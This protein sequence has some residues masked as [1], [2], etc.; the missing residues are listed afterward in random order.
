LLVKVGTYYGVIPFPYFTSL[1][2][3]V[4]CFEF[5]VCDGAK[6]VLFFLN[7]GRFLSLFF[8]PFSPALCA[9]PNTPPSSGSGCCCVVPAFQLLSIRVSFAL[10]WNCFCSLP[11]RARRV[12]SEGA[13][14]L[15][16]ALVA[17][18][19]RRGSLSRLRHL[20]F[21]LPVLEGPSGPSRRAQGQRVKRGEFL[22]SL[23]CLGP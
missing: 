13:A 20:L 10:A 9:V 21:F 12:G 2:F 22:R 8:A 11:S 18:A 15:A 3:N 5:D 17:F 1:P 7:L 6:K 14:L 19:L 4:C 16:F 23:K